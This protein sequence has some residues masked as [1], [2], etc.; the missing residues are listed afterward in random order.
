[1]VL[2]IRAVTVSL[3][4]QPRLVIDLQCKHSLFVIVFLMINSFLS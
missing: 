2:F 1:M 3:R 4:T